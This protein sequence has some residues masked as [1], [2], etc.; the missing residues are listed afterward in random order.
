[1][2]C[3]LFASRPG[4]ACPLKAGPRRESNMRPGQVP[5]L[6]RRLPRSFAA[7]GLC[8]TSAFTSRQ[9]CRCAIPPVCSILRRDLSSRSWNLGECDRISRSSSSSSVTPNNTATAL[10][11]RVTTTGPSSVSFKYALSRAL[12]STTDAIFIPH[13]ILHLVRIHKREGKL[14][15]DNQ[16]YGQTED[17]NQRWCH[18]R[19]VLGGHGSRASKRAY[20]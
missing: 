14:F 18:A 7:K 15:H 13:N 8:C 12:T 4:P 9:N 16:H 11:L 20:F 19:R 10:P 17:R 5:R 2:G 6:A 1:M 3:P